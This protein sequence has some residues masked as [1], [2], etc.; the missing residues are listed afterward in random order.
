MG[1]I[2]G[3]A[4]EGFPGGCHGRAGRRMVGVAAILIRSDRTKSLAVL[5]DAREVGATRC[6][7]APG[8]VIQRQGRIGGGCSMQAAHRDGAHEANHVPSY[9]AA[10]SLHGDPGI[11]LDHPHGPFAVTVCRRAG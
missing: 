7:V 4:L 9:R 10:K 3:H 2:C 8:G 11:A 1:V 6:R 5:Y